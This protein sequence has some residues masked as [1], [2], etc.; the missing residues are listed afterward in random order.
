METPVI[1][2]LISQIRNQVRIVNE[3]SRVSR[4]FI[5]SLIDKHARWLIKRESSKLRIMKMDYLFQTL[6]CVSVIEVPASD[7]CCGLKTKCKIWRTRDKIPSV[8]TDEDGIILKAVYSV[9]GSEEFTPI[10]LQ[11]FMRKIENPHSKY[12]KAR[13]YYYNNGYLYFPNT[14][15][16]VVQVKGYFI[17]EVINSCK[18]GD[19]EKRCMPNTDKR[20][21]IPDYL[22]GELMDHVLNDM[23]NSKKVPE[24]VK[25]DKNTNKLN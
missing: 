4:R 16:K 18:P 20:L 21:R 12:D 1:G 2:Q 5:W 17:D 6:K 24:D 11:E 15:I 14:H 8:Y 3:D 9:D 7:E 10:K 25:I 23:I 19:E 13:Y 22:L